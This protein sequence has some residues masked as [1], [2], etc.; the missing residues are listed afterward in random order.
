LKVLIDTNIVVDN[1]ARRDEYGDSLEILNLCENRRLEGVVSTVTIMDVMYILRKYMGSLEARRAV[2]MLMQ[3]VD[4]VPALE[5]DISA[6]LTSDFSDFEDAVQAACA[7]RIK[8]DYIVTR[9]LRDF[10]NS[11]VPAIL[12]D[13]ILKLLQAL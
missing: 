13:D 6:A 12:P 10:K 9:N 4:V 3:I 11:P 7:A 1:L 5:N 8:A 2:S